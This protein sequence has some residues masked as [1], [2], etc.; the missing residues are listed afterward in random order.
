MS[1]TLSTALL[2]AGPAV[3]L[4]LW[5]TGLPADMPAAARL[6][7]GVTIWMGLWW[8]TDVVP[9]AITA[10]VPTL[11]FPLLG[12]LGARETADAYA[13]PMVFLFLGGF[14]VARAMEVVNLHERIA[15]W[16]VL[17]LGGS[18]ARVL[19]GFM[20]ATAVLS[21][22]MSNTATCV[23][24]MP[25]ALGTASF[26]GRTKDGHSASLPLLLGVA[27]AASIGGL[28]T[29]LGTPTNGI[30]AS[31]ALDRYGIELGFAEWLA[32]GGPVA[33]LLVAVTYVY[34]A[35]VSGLGGRGAGDTLGVVQRRYGEL[36]AVTPDERKVGIVFAGMA[37]AW[38]TRALYDDL[39]PI[40]DP[41]I[42][43]LGAG[44]VFALPGQ[45][46]GGRLM[47]WAEGVQIP[48]GVLLLFAGGLA[49]AAGFS[50]S[51]LADYLG[52]KLAALATLPG[53]A[54]TG[55]VVAF[56]N[57]L[58]EVTSN[59]ATASVVL[60][61]LASLADQTGLDPMSLMAGATLA[62]SCAFMLPMA[63]GPNA[64]VFA[65]GELTVAYM[66]KRGFAL[67]LI[68]IAVVSA[69]MWVIGAAH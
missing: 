32:Y 20:V 47:D 57:F 45:R 64:V 68:S 4:L 30:L 26:L 15:L 52:L 55:L 35:W 49:L 54:V 43:V 63:T 61:I 22:W 67:N 51:G 1:R 18:P 58:T 69:W 3:T 62:A 13:H 24:M 21:A 56:V 37:L 12:I 25:L 7:L 34:L 65:S 33:V 17:R 6:A 46:P 48:W 44:L 60:P 11:A 2:L 10:L 42:A 23:M 5:L 59:V 9:M 8:V 50:G 16:V 39:V 28:T 41:G 40:T 29:I 27:Y 53:W 31:I 66:A 14:L 19:L 36:G 38:S